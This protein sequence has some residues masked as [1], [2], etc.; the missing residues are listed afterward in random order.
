M[1]NQWPLLKFLLISYFLIFIW[2]AVKPHDY[3]TW[4]LEVAPALGGLAILIPT[5]LRFPLS[6]LFYV[7]V[8]I[9][10]IIL[11]IGGHYTYAEVPFFNW[12][13]DTLG[14]QRNSYDGVGHFAQGFMPAIYTR[15]ILLRLTPL[16]RGGRLFMIVVS[17][18]LAISAFYELIEWAVA[19]MI[20]EGANDFLGSQ[21]DEWDTQKDMALCFIGS[22]LAQLF[23]NGIHDRSLAKISKEPK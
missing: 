16:K 5:Y 15:E 22:I 3:F 4:F 9:H 14:T 20:G 8:W 11:T 17:I 1:K 12:I 7:L 13:R 18:C 10:A 21:G 19:V 2:S 6:N 23:L